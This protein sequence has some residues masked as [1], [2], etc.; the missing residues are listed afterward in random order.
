[1]LLSLPGNKKPVDFQSLRD[2]ITL[3][4]CFLLAQKSAFVSKKD[5]FNKTP[6]DQ[7]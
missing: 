7:A 5:I 3:K 6:C 4:E 1:M 2:C